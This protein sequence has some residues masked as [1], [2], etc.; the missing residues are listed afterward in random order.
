MLLRKKDEVLDLPS[1]IRSWVPVD[2]TDSPAAGKANHGLLEWYQVTDPRDAPFRSRNCCL[3]RRR[4]QEASR[5]PSRRTHSD[6]A[7]WGSVHGAWEPS[8]T[9]SRVSWPARMA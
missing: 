1:K 2:L 7:P 8:L 9:T 6:L 5:P 4:G 3:S